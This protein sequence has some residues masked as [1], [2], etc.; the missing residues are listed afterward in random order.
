MVAQ[1][2][3]QQENW[4][5]FYQQQP[6]M[7]ILM[8]YGNIRRSPYTLQY[9]TAVLERCQRRADAR[10]RP[11]FGNGLGTVW[12]ALQDLIKQWSNGPLGVGSKI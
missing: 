12:L 3:T 7:D 8:H 6:L 2:D 5:R 11:E 4:T 1:Q 10:L 9:L